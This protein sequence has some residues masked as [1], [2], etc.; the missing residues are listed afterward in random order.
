MVECST[1]EHIH[2]DTALLVDRA[3]RALEWYET[4]EAV[5]YELS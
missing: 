3:L 2:G 4:C 1:R 5:G